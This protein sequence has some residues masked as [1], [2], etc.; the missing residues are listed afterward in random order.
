[1]L[2]GFMSFCSSV[3]QGLEAGCEAGLARADESLLY[4]VNST[5]PPRCHPRLCCTVPS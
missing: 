1:M 5:D 2:H 3:R 4:V